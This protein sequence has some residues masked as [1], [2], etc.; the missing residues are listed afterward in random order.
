MGREDEGRG[1]ASMPEVTT[2]PAERGAFEEALEAFG[3]ECYQ[4]AQ[5]NEDPV[6]EEPGR[7]D[8]ARAAV[9]ASKDAEVQ[10]AYLAG[11]KARK[12]GTIC[13]GCEHA[14]HEGDCP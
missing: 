13:P 5:H 2:P 6:N 7:V 8:A 1:G 3:G 10:A 4:E 9:I 11:R 12:D 14:I